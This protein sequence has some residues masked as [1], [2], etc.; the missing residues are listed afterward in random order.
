MVNVVPCVKQPATVL[1]VGDCIVDR[2]YHGVASKLSP[3]APVPVVAMQGEDAKL[4]GAANVALNCRSLGARV[5][6]LTLLG[7]DKWGEWAQEALAGFGIETD[8]IVTSA[9]R[10]TS[11]KSRVVTNNQQIVRLDSEHTHA[12]DDREHRLLLAAYERVLPQV[13]VVVVSDYAKGVVGDALIRSI[14]HMAKVNAKAVLVDPKGPD[15]T[16]YSGATLLSPNR[17]EAELVLQQSLT[18]KADIEAALVT[19]RE[20][21]HLDYAL[22]TLSEQ[23]VACYDGESFQHEP[24]SSVAVHDVTGAG[25]TF[26]ATCACFLA[27]QQPLRQVLTLA[28]TAA[29]LAVSKAGNAVIGFFDLYE[30]LSKQDERSKLLSIESMQAVRNCIDKPVVFTNG[31]FDLLHVGHISYLKQAR[32]LGGFLIVAVNSDAS[33]RRLKGEHRP[34]N[35][36]ADRMRMLAAYDFVDAVISFDAQ[37]P[38]EVIAALKPDILVKGADYRPEDIVGA[39]LVETTH[40]LAFVP[41][42]STSNMIKKMQTE[43]VDAG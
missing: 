12:L 43:Q 35:S 7:Q 30:H 18:T 15:Y 2:Y 25:D 28:N 9:M 8:G 16:K 41:G 4:G 17:K 24:T 3:E 23:G 32:A 26:I 39:D 37:T 36:L 27:Q 13:E 5:T 29:T 33:V 42:K 40:V 31:C 38:Y 10:K 1:V 21:F 22:I 11:V 34:I 14:I 20:Q 6:F 19:M